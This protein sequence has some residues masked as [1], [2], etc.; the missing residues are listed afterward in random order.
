ML[1][2]LRCSHPCNAN[3][4]AAAPEPVSGADGRLLC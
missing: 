3:V 1:P 2:E 4:P